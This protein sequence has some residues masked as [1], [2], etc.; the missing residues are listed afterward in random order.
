MKQLTLFDYKQ[1]AEPVRVEVETHVAAAKNE[2]KSAAE[3][4][5]NIGREIKALRDLLTDDQFAE[6]LAAEFNYSDRTARRYIRLHDIFGGYDFTG[7]GAVTVEVMEYLVGDSVPPA[8]RDAAVDWLNSGRDLTREVAANLVREQRPELPHTIKSYDEVLEARNRKLAN[9]WPVALI[10]QL[11]GCMSTGCTYPLATRAHRVPHS[12]VGENHR[13]MLLCPNCHHTYD[14]LFWAKWN[15]GSKKRKQF[16]AVLRD[17]L[18]EMPGFQ[19]L[20]RVADEEVGWLEKYEGEQEQL[21]TH[22]NGNGGNGN[23]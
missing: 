4:I 14:T 16:A 12:V 5:V 2:M 18:G 22:V 6:L 10:E 8:A 19:E 13:V 17:V 21:A 20:E 11:S 7:F 23:G 1:L 15:S 9:R 3:S